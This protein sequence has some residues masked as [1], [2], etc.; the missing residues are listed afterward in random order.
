M[1]GLEDLWRS[2]R[3]PEALDIDAMLAPPTA[4]AAG[5]GAGAAAAANGAAAADAG[6]LTVGGSAA[7][8]LGLSDAHAAWDARQCAALFVRCVRA[9]LEERPGELGAAVV[10][11]GWGG[12]GGSLAALL[13][14][15]RA[16]RCTLDCAL[17][18]TPALSPP[19]PNLQLLKTV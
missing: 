12:G 3:P 17:S 4:A 6:P 10:S 15:I 7:K 16:L 5:Q 8:A 2:R 9:Y 1:R 19:A 13:A 18:L 14:A 11:G